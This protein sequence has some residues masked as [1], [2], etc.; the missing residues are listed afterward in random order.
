M[1]LAFPVD[2]EIMMR[3]HRNRW[4]SCGAYFLG[5]TMADI[6]FQIGFD[7]LFIIIAYFVSGQIHNI[8]RFLMFTT[9]LTLNSVAVQSMGLLIGAAA[10]SVEA[11]T[12]IGPI[13]CFPPLLLAGFFIKK[14]SLGSFQWLPKL[15]FAHYAFEGS[16]LSLY[17]NVTENVPRDPL[18]C[19]SDLSS[20]LPQNYTEMLSQ[21]VTTKCESK[22]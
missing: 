17:G 19:S 9:I 12:F 1:V 3:E 15:S 11:A 14:D 5:K 4:Y 8:W 13:C 21:N 16:I 6:P 2:I 22:F 20:S 18:Q 7:L 10:P